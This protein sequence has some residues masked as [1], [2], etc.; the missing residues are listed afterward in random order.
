MTLVQISDQFAEFVTNQAS[1]ATLNES[2]RKLLKRQAELE[3]VISDYLKSINAEA[4]TFKDRLITLEEKK[5]GVKPNPRVHT[6]LVNEYL[7]GLGLTQEAINIL[8]QMNK[9]QERVKSRVQILKN[10]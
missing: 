7:L 4:V 6:A 10:E 1:L 5:Y 2:R 3:T 8:H 9:A